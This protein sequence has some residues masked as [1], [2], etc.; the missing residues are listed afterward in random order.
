[1]QIGPQC[2]QKQTKK[3]LF[4]F[5]PVYT[6]TVEFKRKHQDVLEMQTFKVLVKFS[7]NCLVMFHKVSMSVIHSNVF[8]S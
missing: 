5:F 2:L 4:V 8:W 6:V 7:I 3:H 1:M